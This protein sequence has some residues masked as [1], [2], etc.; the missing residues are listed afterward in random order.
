MLRAT[1]HPTGDYHSEELLPPFHASIRMKLR[2]HK[3]V[4]LQHHQ[5]P[6]TDLVTPSNTLGAESAYELTEIGLRTRL[7]LAPACCGPLEP[8][9]AHTTRCLRWQRDGPRSRIPDVR[10]PRHRRPARVQKSQTKNDHDHRDD[11]RERESDIRIGRWMGVCTQ[12]R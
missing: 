3:E 11:P 9:D 2:D 7:I 10:C 12:C 8:I 6:E 5:G 4:Q 1:S